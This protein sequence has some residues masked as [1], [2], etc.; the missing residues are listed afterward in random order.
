[1]NKTK[2]ILEDIKMNTFAFRVCAKSWGLPLLSCGIKC[3]NLR[4]PGV[5]Y[6]KEL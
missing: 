4:K 5:K 1:M 6:F 2:S 3:T